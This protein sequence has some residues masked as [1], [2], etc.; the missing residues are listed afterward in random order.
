MSNVLGI[1]LLWTAKPIS[2]QNPIIGHFYFFHVYNTIMNL[3][4]TNGVFI[5]I[6]HALLSSDYFLV[7]NTR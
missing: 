6:K 1:I 3:I 7:T 4:G 5:Q 2:L